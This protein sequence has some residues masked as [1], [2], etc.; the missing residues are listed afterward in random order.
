MVILN[1]IADCTCLLVKSA[2]TLHSKRFHHG[3]LHAVDVMAVPN[4]SRNELTNRKKTRFWTARFP[5]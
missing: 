3:Y 2:S 5:R 1:D 4:G